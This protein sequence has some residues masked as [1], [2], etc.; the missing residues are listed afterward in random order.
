MLTR[1][2]RMRCGIGDRLRIPFMV[3]FT[4]ALAGCTNPFAGFGPTRGSIF[5]GGWLTE[6]VS[7]AQVPVLYCYGTIGV[8]DC[9]GDALP[10]DEGDR[11]I[12][13]SGPESGSSC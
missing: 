11:L 7:E 8:A 3:A 12:G 6:D 1:S 9:H 2:R 4:L 10:A 5:A 13:H